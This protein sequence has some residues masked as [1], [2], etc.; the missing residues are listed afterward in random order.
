MKL[1][2]GSIKFTKEEYLFISIGVLLSLLMAVGAVFTESYYLPLL[3][4]LALV[5]FIYLIFVFREPFNGLI[6]AIVYCFFFYV[7]GREI[8]GGIPYGMGIEILLGVTLLSVWYNADKMDFSLLKSNLF[9]LMLFWFI[10]SILEIA[11]PAGASM[12]G[13]LQEIRGV[14]LVPFMLV[15]LG[16][17]LINNLKRVKL[18]VILILTFSLIGALNGIKQKHIGLSA[19]EQRW[20]DAVGYITHILGGNLR[21]FSFY[22]EAAQFGASMG[23][24]VSLAI[25]LALGVKMWNRKVFLILCGGILFYGML[26]SGT[27][28]ALFAL[29]VSAVFSI[30]LTKRIRVIFSGGIV[31]MLFFCFLKFTT[32]GNTN[33]G[34]FRLRSAVN[35]QDKSLNLRFSNQQKLSDYL[36]SRPFGG[37]LGVIGAFGHAFNSDKYLSTIEPDSYWVKLWAEYGIVGFTLWFCMMMYFLGSITGIVWKTRDP[38][39]RVKLCGLGGSVAGLFACS[40]GNEVMNNMPS[41]LVIYLSLAVLFNAPRLDKEQAPVK[42]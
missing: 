22:S 23:Q 30:F 16:L 39:L 29:L 18:F 40:Y 28:G 10:L 6:G 15:C 2:P 20:L 25:V 27:R 3:P 14:A 35:P 13:W 34:I 36:S 8:D 17:L 41:S 37:G 19:G 12:Q 1:S 24:F 32:I 42:T 11:N 5:A 21:I 4:V 33:Y 26:I 7:L 38:N 31:L 9:F